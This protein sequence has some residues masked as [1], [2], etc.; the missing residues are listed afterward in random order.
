MKE[1]IIIFSVSG[2]KNECCYDFFKKIFIDFSGNKEKISLSFYK[3]IKHNIFNGFGQT[4]YIN[5]KKT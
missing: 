5:N 2:I 4:I 3:K 1:K